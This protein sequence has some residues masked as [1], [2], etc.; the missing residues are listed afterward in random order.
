MDEDTKSI[1]WTKSG[2]IRCDDFENA[3][4]YSK[5]EGLIE[6]S[7]EDAEGLVQALWYNMWGRNG[8]ET[9]CLYIGKEL[10]SEGSYSRSLAETN[11][12]FYG[13][14]VKTYLETL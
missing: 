8:I 10:D 5:V 3:G 12:R 7:L 13:E 9:P 1:I 11:K 2:C 14:D 4:L 6:Y